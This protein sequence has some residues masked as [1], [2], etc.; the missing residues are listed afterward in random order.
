MAANKPNLAP[1]EIA[2]LWSLVWSNCLASGLVES[3]PL[4]SCSS[5]TVGV[6]WHPANTRLVDELQGLWLV[7]DLSALASGHLMLCQKDSKKSAPVVHQC[8]CAPDEKGNKPSHSLG[9]ATRV[10]WQSSRQFIQEIMLPVFEGSAVRSYVNVYFDVLWYVHWFHILNGLI[11]FLKRN[12][13]NKCWL[14][15]PS[16]RHKKMWGNMKR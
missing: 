2:V 16:T 11:V 12:C 3:R 9:R 7:N 8:C 15:P 5:T 6:E 14:N 10:G 1:K 13:L 4:L